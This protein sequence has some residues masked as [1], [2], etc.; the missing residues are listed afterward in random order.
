MEK[1]E[2]YRY[3]LIESLIEEDFFPPGM[4][5]GRLGGGDKFSFSSPNSK[6]R[7]ERRYAFRTTARG[8]P[9]SRT[10]INHRLYNRSLYSK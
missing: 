1:I 2:K 7:K 8:F 9:T 5:A 6:N 10:H 4:D 3:L